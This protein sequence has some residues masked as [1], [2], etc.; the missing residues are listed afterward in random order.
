M[1]SGNIKKLEERLR[2]RLSCSVRA[3]VPLAAY[4]TFGI[5]G[6]ADLLIEPRTEEEVRWVV[7][8]C[9]ASEVPLYVMGAG[10]NLVVPDDGV[11]GVVLRTAGAMTAS[12]LVGEVIECEAGV[13]DADLAKRAL[14]WSVTGFEWIYDIPGSVGGAVYMNAGNNDGEMKDSIVSVRWLDQRGCLR[15]GS[16]EQ[17]EMGYRT[18]VFHREPGLVLWTALKAVRGEPAEIRE[19]MDSIKA[20]RHSKFPAE[21]LCAGSVF[22]RPQGH[23]A[24]KL[25]EDA[26]CGGLRIGDAMVSQKHKGFIVNTGSATAEQ[27]IELIDRV[28]QTVMERFGVE[29]QPEVELFTR[30]RFL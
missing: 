15:E 1:A 26:G 4:T 16:V 6:P 12:K 19:K 11:R 30:K 18:S 13:C 29:L 8:E 14:E 23:Y 17:L 24:G 5:G 25:I 9:G 3:G 7:E 28:R 27:V 21:A 20:L 22:K 2:G 10:S